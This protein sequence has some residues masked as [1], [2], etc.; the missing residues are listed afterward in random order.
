MRHGEKI[1]AGA[2]GI[3]FLVIVIWTL[4][5]SSTAETRGFE[6][7][8]SGTF[9]VERIPV[10][11]LS[12]AVDWGQPKSQGGRN[13]IFDIFT[14][15]VIYYDEE[16]GTFTVTPP[17]P[18]AEAVDEAFELQLVEVKPVPY[19]FQLVS[20]A[21]AQG[22]YVLTLEDLD[23]GRDVFCAPNESL[24]EHGLEVLNFSEARVVASSRSTGYHRSV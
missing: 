18:G 8:G 3:L 11:V 6:T 20:Y 4:L 7:T 2:A 24:S 15:P 12:D 1:V 14:P 21:G 10:D 5:S 17:F 9:A 19:R 13:W 16:T 22:N 23:S